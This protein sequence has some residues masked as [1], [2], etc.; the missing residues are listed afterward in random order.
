MTLKIFRSVL[1][2]ADDFTG[3]NDTTAQFAKLGFSTITTLDIDTVPMLMKKYDVVAV[4]TESRALDDQ[5]AKDQLQSLGIRIR[6]SFGNTL[7]YKKIDS[8][9]RGNIVPEIRGLYDALEPDLVVFAPAFPK[10]ERIIR[11]GILMVKGVPVNQTYFGKDIRTPVKSASIPDYFNVSFKEVYHHISLKELRSG[12]IRELISSSRVISSDAENDEDLKIIVQEVYGSDKGNIIWVGSAG[13][14]ESIAYNV[15]IGNRKGKPVLMAV[16][17]PNDL[18]KDQVKTFTQEFPSK[19][20]LVKID[21]LVND[22]ESECRRVKK[23]VADTLASSS[24]IVVTISYSP[25]QIFEGEA[26]AKKLG[27][28]MSEFGLVLAEKFGNLVSAIIKGFG[29][30][31]FCG[32]FITGGDVAVSVI[33]SLNIDALELKGEIEPGLPVLNYNGKYIVTKAGGFG[34]KGTLIKIAARLKVMRRM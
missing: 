33:R 19:L 25:S 10:Q 18:A 9:M 6:K 1:I 8:T 12:R 30:S 4:D 31:Q 34:N 11:N 28:S 24:D 27:V 5:K 23:E 32:L 22:F 7:V 21:V 20:V 15:I 14:A 13:L 17:S 29:W 16:G 26:M 3:A 2:I